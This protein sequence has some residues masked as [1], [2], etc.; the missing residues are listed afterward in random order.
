MTQS[1][2]NLSYNLPQKGDRNKNENYKI[3]DS[4]NYK[5][6]NLK[7]KTNC[8]LYNYENCDLTS[9]KNIQCIIMKVESQKTLSILLRSPSTDS[10]LA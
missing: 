4:T 9:N 3:V 10:F 5:Q 2:N 8:T 6:L 1:T 7:F